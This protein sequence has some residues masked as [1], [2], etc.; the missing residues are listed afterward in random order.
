MSEFIRF[1]STFSH[2]L[3]V[4]MHTLHMFIVNFSVYNLYLLYIIP[5]VCMCSCLRVCVCVCVCVCVHAYYVDVHLRH[6]VYMNVKYIRK[7][8]VHVL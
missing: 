8:H 1:K 4:G 2:L 5:Y 7:V 6:T 3:N